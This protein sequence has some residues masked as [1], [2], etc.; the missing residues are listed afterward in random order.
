LQVAD[1]TFAIRDVLRSILGTVTAQLIDS[2]AYIGPRLEQPEQLSGDAVVIRV[3][4]L[5][6]LSRQVTIGHR[7]RVHAVAVPHAGPVEQLVDLRRLLDRVATC[8]L[9]TPCGASMPAS[10]PVAHP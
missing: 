2:V 10:F 6:L 9:R 5:F 1:D 4:A 8:R 3:T 7:W